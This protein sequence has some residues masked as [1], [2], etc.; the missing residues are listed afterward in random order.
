VLEAEY[1]QVLLRSGESMRVSDH[2]VYIVSR[3]EKDPPTR[4]PVI[5]L[6]RSE[7]IGSSD[8]LQ[9]RRNITPELE[10]RFR[11]LDI[12]DTSTFYIHYDFSHE[13]RWYEVGYSYRWYRERMHRVGVKLFYIITGTTVIILVLFPVFFYRNL[14]RIDFKI[15]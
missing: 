2:V 5:E 8:F 6:S 10:R 11:Y 3:S 13:N 15:F 14:F 4:Y 12:E 7:D 9:R 1:L